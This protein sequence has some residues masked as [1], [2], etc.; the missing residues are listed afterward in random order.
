MPRW[1]THFDPLLDTKLGKGRDLLKVTPDAY[2]HF[3][4][5]L[6]YSTQALPLNTLLDT[7]IR[8]NADTEIDPASCVDWVYQPER[9]I[10]HVILTDGSDSGGQWVDNSL[11]TDAN[12]RTLSYSEML[13]LP[14]Y[15]FAEHYELQNRAP[16][17]ELQRPSRAEVADY[18]AVYPHAVGIQ[19]S[20]YTGAHVNSVSRTRNGFSIGSHEIMCKNLVLA[21]GIFSQTITPPP[22]LAPLTRLDAPSEPLL[23]VGSGFSA[24]DVIISVPPT[25]KIVHIFRWAPDTR[26]SPLRGCHHA[27]YPEYAGI[28][29]QMKLASMASNRPRAASPVMGRK[30]SNSFFAHR[31]WASVYEGLPNAEIVEVWNQGNSVRLRIRLESGNIVDRTVGGLEYVVGRRGNLDYLSSPLRREVLSSPEKF[32]RPWQQGFP[33]SGRTLRQKVEIDFEVAPDVFAIGSLTGDSLVRHAFGG[34]VAA[35]SQIMGTAQTS[36]IQSSATA[37]VKN[38]YEVQ[39]SSGAEHTDLH[40]DRRDIITR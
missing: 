23:V 21:T 10:A 40:I 33:V 17:P 11:S 18:Y 1:R 37:H 27:A 3:Y 26:P 13:S 7:L 25:R 16:L 29:R 39:V 30:K 8:P 22:L 5:S 35:A 24:A 6:R 31:D 20:L 2:A 12:I 32:E 9:A 15:S 14:G 19:E 4:S 36:K 28:Y 34:C 38:G